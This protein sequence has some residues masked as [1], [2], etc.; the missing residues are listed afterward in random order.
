MWSLL[1]IFNSAT[2]LQKANR[3]CINCVSIKIYLEKQA[4]TIIASE[5]Q[6]KNVA[7]AGVAQ[8]GECQLVNPKVAILILGEGTCLGCGP[9]P[10]LG[11]AVSPTPMF[12][13]LSFCPTFPLSKK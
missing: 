4:G 8:C 12:L 2:V 10:Q 3:Q 6:L 1:Q 13:S 11:I 9:G 5:F 7:L